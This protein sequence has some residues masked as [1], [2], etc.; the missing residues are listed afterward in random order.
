MKQTL[1]ILRQDGLVE[2]SASLL[3]RLRVLIDALE[4]VAPADRLIDCTKLR[5]ISEDLEDARSAYLAAVAQSQPSDGQSGK[6]QNHQARF[7]SIPDA[8][9]QIARQ[10]TRLRMSLQSAHAAYESLIEPLIL[11]LGDDPADSLDL[12][13][14][15]QGKTKAKIVIRVR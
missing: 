1:P 13:A 9:K 5:Q 15:D 14:G 8:A 10:K 3:V 4:K 12:A 6:N 7:G 11:S 2:F